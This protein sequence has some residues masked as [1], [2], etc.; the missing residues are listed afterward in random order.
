[1]DA[2]AKR[3]AH[4]KSK[5][6]EMLYAQVV[7]AKAAQATKPVTD[8]DLLKARPLWGAGGGDPLWGAG[9]RW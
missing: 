3:A 6:T 4:A 2:Q 5:E 1:M 8:K 9:G 7:D